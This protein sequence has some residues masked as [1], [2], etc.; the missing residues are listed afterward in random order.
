MLQ[1]VKMK[2]NNT[3]NRIYC[4][5]ILITLLV[6]INSSGN[7]FP[8]IWQPTNGPLPL[9]NQVV[10]LAIDS[11]GYVFAGT[12]GGG[13][14]LTTDNGSNW[15]AVNNGLSSSNI[16]SLLAV[17]SGSVLAGTDDGVFLSTNNGANWTQLNNGIGNNRV[18]KLAVN[19]SGH[20]FAGTRGAGVFISTDHGSNWTALGLTG[21]SI[22][23]LTINSFGTVYVGTEGLTSGTYGGGIYYSDSNGSYWYQINNGLPSL[24]VLSLVINSLNYIYA[25]TYGGGVYRSTNF[26]S[27]WAQQDT[28]LPANA[29]V[30]SLAVNASSYIYA[31]LGFNHL[32]AYL[33]TDNGNTWADYGLTSNN[34]AAFAIDTAGFL[35]AGTFEGGVYRTYFTTVV[36]PPVPS[37]ISPLNLL[38]DLSTDEGLTWHS[39]FGAVGYRLQL[40]T[41]S[42]FATTVFDSSKI[43]DTSMSIKSLSYETKYFWRVSAANSKVTSNW[44]SVWKFTT[45]HAPGWVAV[46]DSLPNYTIQSLLIN[47]SD[48][49]FA[50]SYGHGVSRST[51][52]G[53]W[54]NQSGLPGTEVYSFAQNSSGY[55]FAGVGYLSQGAFLST[56]QGVTW[57]PIGLTSS[58]AVAALAINS[59]GWVFAGTY[60]NVYITKDNGTNWT[61]INNGLPSG[62]AVLSLAINSSNYIFAGL[63]YTSN[64]LGVYLSKDNGSNWSFS[65]LA[66]CGDIHS[67]AINSSGYIFAGTDKGV[68]LSTD[69]GTNWVQD[70]LAGIQVMSFALTS[71]GKVFTATYGGGMYFSVDNGTN[72]TQINDGL[73]NNNVSS[74]ALNS[75]GYIY[76][77]M[78]GSGVYRA[79][80]SNFIPQ[81]APS[82]KSPV[83]LSTDISITPVF[84]WNAVAG[85]YNYR[86]QLSP[87]SAFSYA[88]FDTVGIKDSSYTV[89]GLS[90]NT[91]YFW[92]VCAN[93]EFGSSIWSNQWS[94]TTTTSQATA[95]TNSVTNITQTTATLNGTVNPKGFSTTVQ[96]DYGPTTG[97]GYTSVAVQSPLTGSSNVSV[98][99]AITNLSLNTLYHYRVRAINTS[100]TVTGPDSTF[101]TLSTLASA[102]TNA[103][104]KVRTVSVTLS[105][106]VNPNNTS[107]VVK[108]QYG[109]TAAYGVTITASQSPL[110]GKSD[111]NV[112]TPVT[113]LTQNTIYHYRVIATNS[114]GT[115]YGSDLTFTTY[116]TSVSL[117]H[118]YTFGDAS[119]SSSYQLIGIP[120]NGSLSLSSVMTGTP[121]QDWTAYYD[122]GNTSDYLVQFDNSS[123]FTFSPGN[124]FWII[125]RNTIN[126]SQSVSSVALDTSGNYSIP[127][128]QGWNIISNPFN[129]SCSWSSIID[130]NGLTASPY[131]YSWT[132]SNWKENTDFSP[133]VGYYIYN[134]L[135]LTSLNI[136]YNSTGKL[137]KISVPKNSA[138]ND[139]TLVKEIEISL[140]KN[141]GKISSVFAA[142]NPK[143]SVDFDQFDHLAP[144]ADFQ[145]ENIAIVNDSLSINYK[146]LI[147]DCRPVIGDGKEFYFVVNNKKGSELKL[148]FNGLSS[149]SSYKCFLINCDSKEF[150]NLNDQN[151]FVIDSKKTSNYKLLIGNDNY[152]NEKKAEF[153]PDNYCLY[154]N[155]PNPFNPATTIRYSLKSDGRVKI[156]VYNILGGLVKELL[157]AA[158]EIGYHEI[159]FDASKLASGIYIYSIRVNPAGGKPGFTSSKKMVL[160]K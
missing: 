5:L 159:Q 73:N 39:S 106:T 94:F 45:I 57:N 6:V 140:L 64:N 76:A 102:V 13:V 112:T 151:T 138:S 58:N 101:T 7:L 130:L 60:G 144:P 75:T 72:W 40:S 116:S 87:D 53:A 46:N 29:D 10:A 11:A 38:T 82:L 157:D 70:G 145:D 155:Y 129:Y 95:V 56:D 3:I 47:S 104:L 20:I 160:L 98:S 36:A 115:S 71:D 86:L 55:I 120:G 34:V 25:G 59:S 109:L 124:G 92:R 61:P 50:G 69:N 113:G 14:F 26:G 31:G 80:I 35:Y 99:A 66:N 128:Q 133:Y 74:L 146:K 16:R 97:Y 62:P 85:A 1:E 84:S 107:T 93:N 125:S 48:Y 79:K 18:N 81:K 67:L 134:S 52:N 43:I 156:S 147:K 41:D 23:A 126:L 28:G 88:I 117:N 17:S 119:Q 136:P 8:Q 90:L 63:G 49:I 103:P 110:S 51:N 27:G 108:F 83:N 44:S 121:K 137:G 96:F 135:S 100:G 158:Q 19:S 33:S 105:G 143:A 78:W 132:N 54:W 91:K 77:G 153:A 9:S 32:G 68:F 149:F 4:R 24:P 152:I 118:Q 150:F 30:Y 2:R 22:T 12:I 37:L 123:A 142:V 139:T 65:G 21:V 114:A 131:L 148:N 15:T 42:T 111:I 141:S 89:H 122:N 127:L 154:Q